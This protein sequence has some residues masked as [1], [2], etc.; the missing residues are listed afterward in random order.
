MGKAWDIVCPALVS[1]QQQ[2]GRNAPSD[3][4]GLSCPTSSRVGRFGLPQ[5]RE[6]NGFPQSGLRTGTIFRGV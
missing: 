3:S 2:A 1:S 4:P 5:A 6:A